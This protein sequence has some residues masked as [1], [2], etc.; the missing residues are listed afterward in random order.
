MESAPAT[1]SHTPSSVHSQ[2][3]VKPH[4]FAPEHFLSSSTEKSQQAIPSVASAVAA[5]VTGSNG[6]N[7]LLRSAERERERELQNPMSR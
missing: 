4:H 5:A 2:H 3:D 7:G 6:F 1:R